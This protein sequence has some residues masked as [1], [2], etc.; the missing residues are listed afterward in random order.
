[1]IV[2][3]TD[4]D[5]HQKREG[6]ETAGALMSHFIDDFLEPMT[7]RWGI[8][9][10]RMLPEIQDTHVDQVVTLAGG[11]KFPEVFAAEFAVEMAKHMPAMAAAAAVSQDNEPPPSHCLLQ[12]LLLQM[13]LQLIC[14]GVSENS[15]ADEL[16]HVNVVA[17]APLGPTMLGVHAESG[18]FQIIIE[19][20][21]IRCN[22]KLPL[23]HAVVMLS[24]IHI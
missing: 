6:K 8:H 4:N 13:N 12:P 23:G 20:S 2:H 15:T 21:A 9:K 14:D 7:E 24:L 11:S 22:K 16:D 18:S 5:V 1:M 10:Y 19:D 3:R 17:R